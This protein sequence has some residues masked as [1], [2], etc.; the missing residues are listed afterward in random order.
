M[1][2]Y[3]RIEARERVQDRMEAL[4]AE[5]EQLRR[6]LSYVTEKLLTMFRKPASERQADL[7]EICDWTLARAALT[8]TGEQS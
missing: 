3:E 7:R 6:E 1:T 4:E 8:V 2:D 5:N